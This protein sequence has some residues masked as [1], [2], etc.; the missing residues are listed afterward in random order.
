MRIKRTKQVTLHGTDTT[1]VAQITF[2]ERW[3]HER[4]RTQ[5]ATTQ[6]WT[7]DDGDAIVVVTNEYPIVVI[8][9]GGVVSVVYGCCGGLQ[10][11]MRFVGLDP[12]EYKF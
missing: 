1:K 6:V 2:N 10:D 4:T 11:A 5:L 7:W 12:R 8:R 3:Q 9:V